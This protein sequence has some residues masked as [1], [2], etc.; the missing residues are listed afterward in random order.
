VF[1]RTQQ[2]PSDRWGVGATL[3]YTSQDRIPARTSAQLS[4]TIRW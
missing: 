2:F 3:A 1:A 4:A